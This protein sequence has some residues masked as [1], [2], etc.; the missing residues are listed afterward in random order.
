VA[1]VAGSEAYSQ[2]NT[3]SSALKGW[4]SCHCTPVFSLQVTD[5]P[6]G[7][8]PAV[9]DIRDLGGEHRDDVPV[10]IPSRQRLV[11]NPRPFGVFGPHREMGG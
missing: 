5:M 6:S 9:L 3:T 2:L 10:G 7:S 4:P 8:D 11:K 1:A